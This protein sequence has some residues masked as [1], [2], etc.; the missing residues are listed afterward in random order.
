MP[1]TI[2][3]VPYVNNRVTHCWIREEE[4]L[5]REMV[6]HDKHPLSS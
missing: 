3:N 1:G 2:F 6:K 4:P 5:I